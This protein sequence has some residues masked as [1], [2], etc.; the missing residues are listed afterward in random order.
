[1]PRV[2]FNILPS[3]AT[4]AW[5]Y[6]IEQTSEGVFGEVPQGLVELEVS[7]GRI[8]A[9]AKVEKEVV[10]AAEVAVVDNSQTAQ[11]VIENGSGKRGRKAKE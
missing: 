1:M 10:K 4:T 8:Q 9:P 6:Q 2:K 7:A 3:D 11:D 5:G